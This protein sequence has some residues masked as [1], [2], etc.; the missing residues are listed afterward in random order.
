MEY[1]TLPSDIQEINKHLREHFGIHTETG[2]EM[3]RVSWSNDQY[4]KRLT[5]TTDEGLQLLYPEVRELPKYQWI[6]SRWILE[7]LCG[8]PVQH[9]RELPTIKLSYECAWVFKDRTDDYI[10]PV[11]E[12][13]KF[14]VDVIYSREG[15]PFPR[16]IDP[17]SEEPLEKQ[18]ERVDKLVEELFGD[19]SDLMMRTV[20]GEAV[21]VPRNYKQEN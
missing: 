2:K 8:V 9:V 17:D 16:Y 20:T 5:D 14:I 12:A 19:E 15:K 1:Q 18:K 11:F 13:A 4:E 6:R 7:R 10:R 3:W 21:V